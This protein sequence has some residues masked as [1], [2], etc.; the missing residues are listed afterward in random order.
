[1]GLSSHDLYVLGWA[2]P[3]SSSAAHVIKISII[4][5]VFNFAGGAVGLVGSM[6]SVDA[7]GIVPNAC[8]VS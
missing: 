2:L 7:G 3:L 5:R 1:M 8:E 4:T 6:G